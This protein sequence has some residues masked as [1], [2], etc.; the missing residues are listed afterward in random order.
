MSI[1][2][3]IQGPG[4]AKY[5]R[6]GVATVSADQ[7]PSRIGERSETNLSPAGLDNT[8]VIYN[9]YKIKIYRNNI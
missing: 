3:G 9:K 6:Y 4:G 8:E 5:R 1:N 7:N 2:I